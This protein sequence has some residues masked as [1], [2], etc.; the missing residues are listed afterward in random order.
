[1]EQQKVRHIPIFVEGRDEPVINRDHV[2]SG[3]A[4]P[5][6]PSPAPQN[7]SNTSAFASAESFSDFPPHHQNHNNFGHPPMNFGAD[8]GFGQD[9]PMP[10][11]SI[12]DRAKDFPVRDFFN[13]RSGSPRRSESPSNVHRQSPSGG[14]QHQRQGTPQNQDRQVPVQRSTTPQRQQAP[15][16]QQRQQAPPNQQHVPPPQQ[17][18]TEHQQPIPAKQKA[19]EDSITK[20]QKIQASVLELMSRVEKYD[21][22]NRKEYAFLDEMLTQNLLK[23]DDI[24]AEGKENIKNARREAIKCINSLI[25]LLEAKNDEASKKPSETSESKPEA[26]PTQNGV[27]GASRNSSYDNIKQT[28]SNNSVNMAEVSA[29]ASLEAKVQAALQKEG[30][31]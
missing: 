10:T 24:D 18:P 17:V 16:Q 30:Q 29:E 3:A 13:M 14:Q 7:S 22:S 28:P 9:M 6:N 31:K 8:M 20:I 15:P 25:S 4:P 26:A 11:G 2:D 23:L 21:G 27:N 1:M 12:F 5:S 19:I